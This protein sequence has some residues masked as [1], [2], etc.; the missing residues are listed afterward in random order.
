MNGSGDL[1]VDLGLPADVDVIAALRRAFPALR[2]A[3]A[4]QP[5]AAEL[6][7]RERDVLTLL[8]KGVGYADIAAML[9]L[10]LG[11]VQTHVKRLYAKLEVNSK[12]EA[13]LVAAELN[14]V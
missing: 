1:V 3:R 6:S 14:L 7:R 9:G 4:P 8:A 2:V 5:R 12:A 13:A 11:T 10:R